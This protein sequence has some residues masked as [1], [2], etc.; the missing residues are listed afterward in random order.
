MIRTEILSDGR[1]HSW[2]DEGYKIRQMDTGVIYED[3][4]DV[5]S[6]SYEETDLVIEPSDVDDSEILKILLGGS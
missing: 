1:I 2:S 5:V 4:I 3:A 6:H